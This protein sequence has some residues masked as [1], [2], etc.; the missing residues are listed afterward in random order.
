MSQMHNP[1]HPSAVLKEA[2]SD[3]SVTDAA[4]RLGVGRV[5]EL[6][7]RAEVAGRENARVGGPEP[8][9]DTDAVAV[10]FYTRRVQAEP[11]DVG[12]T[13]GRDQ[14][15][16]HPQLVRAAGTVQIEHPLRAPDAIVR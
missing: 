15:R 16:V 13:T 14:D 12:R 3:I 5:G 4:K 6:E 7:G 1:C 2:L 8:V 11:L 9:V 10:E